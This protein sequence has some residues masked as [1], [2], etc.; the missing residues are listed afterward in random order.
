MQLNIKIM[1]SLKLA[2]NSLKSMAKKKLLYFKNNPKLI[3]N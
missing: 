2:L 1:D 3:K